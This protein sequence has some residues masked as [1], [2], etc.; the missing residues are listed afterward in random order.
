M[1]AVYVVNQKHRNQNTSYGSQW[2]I[3][4]AE[5]QQCLVASGQCG[6]ILDVV[7]WGLHFSDDVLSYLGVTVDRTR[8]L[9]VAKFVASSA[10]VVWHG[11]PADPEKNIQDIP[12]EKILGLWLNA[13][14]LSAAKI[15]K[16]GRGQPCR[17]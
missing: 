15:R 13:S 2:T 14:V 7:G 8:R 1:P 10:P 12:H 16:L 3:T 17:L 11:Y 5:E 9:F 6:W 4:P